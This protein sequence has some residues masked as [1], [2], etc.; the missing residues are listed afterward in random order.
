MYISKEILTFAGIIKTLESMQEFTEP[1]RVG[2]VKVINPELINYDIH[3]TV[4][5]DGAA[6]KGD[7]YPLDDCQ[8]IQ[9]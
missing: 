7:Y 2:R 5:S 1:A 9:P 8:F 4:L 3:F 6:S